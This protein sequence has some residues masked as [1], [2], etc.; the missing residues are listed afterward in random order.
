VTCEEATGLYGD[1]FT[2]RYMMKYPPL[3]NESDC[4]Q[5]YLNKIQ[6]SIRKLHHRISVIMTFTNNETKLVQLAFCSFSSI[7]KLRLKS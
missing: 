4:E 6:N 1:L 3:C 7:G 2:T 5:R